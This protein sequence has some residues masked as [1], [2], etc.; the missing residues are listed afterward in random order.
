MAMLLAAVRHGVE[1]VWNADGLQIG[2]K[3]VTSCGTDDALT[4]IRRATCLLGPVLG[5]ETEEN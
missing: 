1:R 5:A 4:C 2:F 3:F